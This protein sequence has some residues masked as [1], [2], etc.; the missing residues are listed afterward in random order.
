[1][2][3]SWH[4]Y[5]VLNVEIRR[6]RDGYVSSRQETGRKQRVENEHASLLGKHTG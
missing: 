5:L 6:E 1:M 4:Q 3:C 2:D